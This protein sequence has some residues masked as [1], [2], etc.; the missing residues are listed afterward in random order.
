MRTRIGILC[1]RRA[2]HS[3]AAAS[4]TPPNSYKIVPGRTTAAQNSG[5]P[6]PLPIRVS[7]GI[8]VTDLCGN[9]RTYSRPSPRMYCVAAIRPASIV[10]ALTQPP[11]TACNPNSPKTTRWPRVALPFIRPLWLFRCLTLLGISAIGLV[12]VHALVNPNLNANVAL[13]RLGFHK[14][15]VDLCAQCAERDRPGDCF[16]AAGH[17][18]AAQP[19]RELNLNSFGAGLHRLI[20]H[21]LH[22][23][24]EAGPLR[25][26]F[27]D[28]LRHEMRLQL[29]ARNFFD[30][31]VDAPPHEVLQ[32]VLQLI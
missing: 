12:L 31:N 1:A 16:F 17:F 7:S 11:C 28:F 5:S 14:T 22:R 21:A 10:W 15:V 19:A 3:F 29:G 4:V 32:L 18:G 2:K 6:L 23:A 27:G 24:A 13:G 26:L 30:F 20:E 9:T 8:D 25:E